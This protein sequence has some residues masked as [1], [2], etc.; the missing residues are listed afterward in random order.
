MCGPRMPLESVLRIVAEM[1]ME[2][3]PLLLCSEECTEGV[4]QNLHKGD[5][6]PQDLHMEDGAEAR[7]RHVH[8]LKKSVELCVHRPGLKKRAEAPTMIATFSILKKEAPI[9]IAN[10][11]TSEF[12]EFP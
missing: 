3:A 7:A 5:S 8:H 11:C 9:M 10:Y 12:R 2:R 1:R 6:A 4:P